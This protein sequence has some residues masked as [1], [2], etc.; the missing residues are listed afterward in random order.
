[1]SRLLSC[2][3]FQ[4]HDIAQSQRILHRG[5]NPQVDI[6]GTSRLRLVNVGVAA[7]DEVINLAVVQDGEPFSEVG[8]HKRGGP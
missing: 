8:V 3:P 1:M 5:P 4:P 2:D 6:F 7:D